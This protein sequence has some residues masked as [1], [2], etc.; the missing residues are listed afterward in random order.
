MGNSKTAKLPRDIGTLP[1]AECPLCHKPNNCTHK[2]GECK[3]HEAVRI[4]R[5]NAACQKVRAAIR[6]TSKGGG[7][8]HTAPDLVLISSCTGIPSQIAEES[9]DLQSPYLGS[10]SSNEDNDPHPREH[11]SHSRWLDPMPNPSRVHRMRHTD[12]SRDPR[13]ETW[14][15]SAVDG[16]SEC[17]AAPRRIPV[18]VLSTEE[19]HE[20][21]S[22]GHGIIPDH[23]YTRGVLDLPTPRPDLLQQETLQPHRRRDRLL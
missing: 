2:A 7:A 12:V 5:H 16:D 4:N 23:I 8:L 15:L 22:A 11:T 21:Y 10:P 9:F 1:T 13:Y 19:T 18:W 20:L 3:D 6:K 17:T 14:S